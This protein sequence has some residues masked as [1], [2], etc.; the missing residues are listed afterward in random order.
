MAT[1]SAD[2]SGTAT[3]GTHR[4]VTAEYVTTGEYELEVAGERVPAEVSL[5]PFYDP[6]NAKVKS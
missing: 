2:R 1:R 6:T 3:Y 4:G 5:Q